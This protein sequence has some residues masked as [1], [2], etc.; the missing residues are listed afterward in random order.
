MGS[1]KQSSLG[2]GACFVGEGEG[3]LQQATLAHLLSLTAGA[4]VLLALPPQVGETQARLWW[5]SAL[6][7][8]GAG[9]KG[10]RKE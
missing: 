2:N 8:A 1:K 9:V 6:L 4:L 10:G 3:C 5:L 7:F